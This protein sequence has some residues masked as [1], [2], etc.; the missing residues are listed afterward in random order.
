MVYKNAAPVVISIEWR[1]IL[2]QIATSEFPY[3]HDSL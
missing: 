2:L 3:S 1:G